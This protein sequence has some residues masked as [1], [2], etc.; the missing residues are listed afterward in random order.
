MIVW[1]GQGHKS[2]S[3]IRKWRILNALT[4][5]I[6]RAISNRKEYSRVTH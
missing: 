6:L 2:E 5:M 1:D 3:Y 4:S